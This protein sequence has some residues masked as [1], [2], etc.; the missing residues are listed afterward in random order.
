MNLKYRIIKV[1]FPTAKEFYVAQYKI[2]GIWMSMGIDRGHLF[3]WNSTIYHETWN[4]AVKKC[5]SYKR[6]MERAE[7]WAYKN[8]RVVNKPEDL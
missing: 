5:A 6:D 8:V 4:E 7:E 1:K 3:M 2:M